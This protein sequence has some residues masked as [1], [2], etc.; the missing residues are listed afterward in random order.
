[1]DACMGNQSMGYRYGRYLVPSCDPGRTASFSSGRLWLLRESQQ[2]LATQPAVQ[3][4]SAKIETPAS[5]TD[6]PG[7]TSRVWYIFVGLKKLSSLKLEASPTEI[8][9]ARL[10][11]G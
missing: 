10:S 3:Q 5:P 11:A 4:H 9:Y 7:A 2:T 6:P 1:M 8:E